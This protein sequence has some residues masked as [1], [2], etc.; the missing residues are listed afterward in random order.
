MPEYVTFF[1]TNKCNAGCGHCFYWKELNS[2]LDELNLDEIHKI[3]KTMGDF[4]FLILTGGEPF[5]RDDL[6]EIAQ[7]F[8]KNNGVRKMNI[9]TNGSLPDK[10]SDIV[11]KIITKCPDF[12][13]TLFVSIDGIGADHDKM[14][15]VDGLYKN[16]LKTIGRIKDI[17][18]AHP[19]LSLGVT[20]VYTSFNE[21]TITDIYNHI[22]ANIKPDTINCAFVRGDTRNKMAITRNIDNFVKLQKMIEN[23]LIQSRL[24][25]VSDPIIGDLVAAC[26]F[27]SIYQLI[28]IVKEERYLLP[29]YAGRINVVIY[30]NG[31]VFPCELRD[32]KMGNI[33]ESNYDFKKVWFSKKSDWVREKIKKI[34]CYCTHECNLLPNVLY[35]PKFSLK[36]IRKYLRLAFKIK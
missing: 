30:P 23:D 3:S 9:I 2:K 16:A 32:D 27:E 19:K 22:K 15:G 10:I 5:L 28:K 34:K 17:Q 12:Y 33:R 20:L 14:R 6:D 21:N 18:V 8:Y 24:K 26:K 25:G 11:K 4:L 1:V 7:I 31:D 29:C 36:I 35:N 13:I